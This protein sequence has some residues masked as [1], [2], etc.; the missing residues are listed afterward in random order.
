[1]RIFTHSSSLVLV[2]C[3]A[4]GPSESRNLV[5]G[6]ASEELRHRGGESNPNPM[7]FPK[8]ARPYGRSMSRW[9]ELTWSYIY[10]IAPDQNPS[11]TPPASTAGSTSTARSGSSRRCRGASGDERLAELHHPARAG[12]HAPDV[13]GGERLSVSGSEFPSCA[14]PV[15]LRLPHRAI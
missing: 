10:G 9:A 4:S 2:G 14:G 15:A 5:Q 1:M 8:D 3:G 12:D 11:S 7:L 6:T 13:V